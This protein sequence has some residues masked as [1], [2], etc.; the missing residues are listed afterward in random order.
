[1]I[2]IPVFVPRI[3]KS[4]NWSDPVVDFDLAMLHRG[5]PLPNVPFLNIR[6]KHV[7]LL[8]PKDAWDAEVLKKAAASPEWVGKVQVEAEAKTEDKPKEKAPKQP[9]K[10]KESK[11]PETV[12]ATTVTE[13]DNTG[14]DPING[15]S[16]EVAAGIE[17]QRAAAANEAVAAGEKLV[18]EIRAKALASINPKTEGA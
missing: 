15:E 11:D 10:P 5:E 2:S 6:E 12:P 17:A 8:D 4:K 13:T 1:M 14:D 9:K 18:A 16:A 7:N 3:P